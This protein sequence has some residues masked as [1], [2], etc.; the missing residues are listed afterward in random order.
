MRFKHYLLVVLLPLAIWSSCVSELMPVGVD[1]CGIPISIDGA[2]DQIPTKATAQ[3]FVD[4]D[5][6]GLFAVNYVEG[7]K[8]AGT[9]LT[10]GN[11]ADN[12]KY[13]FDEPGYKWI[14]VHPVYY[15]DVNTHADLYV[16]YPYQGTINEVN[17]AAWFPFERSVP[18]T[19]LSST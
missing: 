12:V 14:P 11:Q 9:L 3:G 1:E 18:A 6:V 15:K 16:Y 4:K 7:N 8:V 17:A 10:K 5:A 2:I 13:V 19:L